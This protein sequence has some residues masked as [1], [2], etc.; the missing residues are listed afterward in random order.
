AAAAVSAANP[1]DLAR[2]L[3]SGT[4]TI[5]VDGQVEPLSTDDVLLSEVP[6]TGWVVESQRDV[7]IALDTTITSE[8]ERAGLAREVVRF[9]QDC[10]KQ[11]GLD[12]T[13][14]ITVR[15]RADGELREAL[16]TSA[17]DIA[18]AVLAVDLAESPTP[19]PNPTEH[20][21]PTEHTDP[22]LNLTIWLHPQPRTP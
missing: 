8:L 7:T 20:P 6:R 5:E 16:L 22:D 9:I 15:W 4:A 13:D 10:R 18:T 17:A 1:A 3:R 11:D 2:D 14:R 19:A 21:G 12:I